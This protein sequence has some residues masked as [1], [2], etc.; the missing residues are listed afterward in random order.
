MT[1]TVANLGRG[2]SLYGFSRTSHPS[3]QLLAA[4]TVNETPRNYLG[5]HARWRSC[6]PRCARP[7]LPSP[8]TESKDRVIERE[9]HTDTLIATNLVNL[10][11]ALGGGWQTADQ[12]DQ[13]SQFDAVGDDARS[14]KGFH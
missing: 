6:G 4:A 9:Y 8:R 2:A 11:R 3:A 10:H 7:T 14:A 12:A 5:Q 13:P 1:V